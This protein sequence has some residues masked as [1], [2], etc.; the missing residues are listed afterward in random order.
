MVD[1]ERQ[2]CQRQHFDASVDAVVVGCALA[3]STG[4]RLLD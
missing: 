3:Q 4:C 2:V 1:V